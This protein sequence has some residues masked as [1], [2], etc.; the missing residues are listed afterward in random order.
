MKKIAIYVLVV[1]MILIFQGCNKDNSLD[2]DKNIENNIT[3]IVEP[4]KVPDPT[5]TIIVEEKHEGE[6]LSKITGL[7][8]PEEIG[9]KRPYAIQFNN[10]KV[11]RNQW[12]IGQA[13]ILYEA[14]VEGGITRLLAIG[15]NFTEDKIGSIRSSRHYFVSI[16]DEYDAIYIHYGKTKYAVAK[17]NEIGIDNID[18]ETGIGPTVFYRDKSI[19]MPNNAFTSLDGILAGIKTKK[20]ETQYKEGYESHFNFYQED[21][22]LVSDKIVSKVNVD[23]SGYNTPYFVY[24]SEEKQYYRYQFGEPHI[25]SNTKDQLSFKNIIIQLVKEWDI[26]KNDY[27]DM[28]LKDASGEGYYITNGKLVPIAWKKLEKNRWMRYYDEAGEELTINPGKTFVAL[29][30]TFRANKLAFETE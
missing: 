5:P 14:L 21:T 1:S 9:I 12:G 19:K 24:N 3:G 20:F 2:D 25:D 13:D 23:Y 29:F 16:A 18:G 7:W 26:D 10:Y 28:E 4:T 17:L 6:V 11:V 22:D 15:E 27:Q 8:V 30:P